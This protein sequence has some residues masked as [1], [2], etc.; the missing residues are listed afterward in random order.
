[1]HSCIYMFLS[2]FTIRTYQAPSKCHEN[3]QLHVVGLD[4]DVCF[5]ECLVVKICY[6]NVSFQNKTQTAVSALWHTEF[7]VRRTYHLVCCVKSRSVL[8]HLV[9]R[10]AALLPCI[11]ATMPVATRFCLLPV[12][13]SLES[14]VHAAQF[15]N[16]KFLCC[17]AVFIFV[18]LS[19]IITCVIMWLSCYTV[20]E[21]FSWL[22]LM[23]SSSA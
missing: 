8:T 6:W 22:M 9:V 1:M 11:R 4:T 18:D 15:I 5:T 3:K 12:Y 10:L 21:M 20:S 23:G 13:L 17:D 19:A 7:L 2:V 16:W 14:S